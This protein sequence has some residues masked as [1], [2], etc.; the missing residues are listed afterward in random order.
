MHSIVASVPFNVGVP[1]ALS[2]SNAR[3]CHF[4]GCVDAKKFTAVF[5]NYVPLPIRLHH[6]EE[7]PKS[8]YEMTPIW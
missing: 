7:E 6:E 4:V 5:C 2:G 1:Q 3:H 8:T